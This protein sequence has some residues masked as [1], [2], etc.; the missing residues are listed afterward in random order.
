MSN[1]DVNT[2]NFVRQRI[3]DSTT[4]TWTDGP[5]NDLNIQALDAD[6]IGLKSCLYLGPITDVSTEVTTGHGNRLFVATSETTF[7]QYAW[8]PD[9]SQWIL[10]KTWPNVNG[11]A[12]PA[13]YGWGK[14]H[15]FYTWFVNL[16]NNINMYWYER[17]I[18]LCPPIFSHLMVCAQDQ[19]GQYN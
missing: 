10:E 3:I 18:I 17:A 14:G 7:G 16:E 8:Y 12:S 19:Y 13:C 1:L 5:L 15:T 4:Y 9:M 11:H 6:R 2:D